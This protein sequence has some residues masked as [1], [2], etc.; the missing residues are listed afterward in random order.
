MTYLCLNHV[1][2]KTLQENTENS[3]T[4]QLYKRSTKKCSLI[5]FLNNAMC[6]SF[7][8]KG[9][10][11]CRLP[12]LQCI[13]FFLFRLWQLSG[14]CDIHDPPTYPNCTFFGPSRMYKNSWEYTPRQ[15]SVTYR[16]TGAT[17]AHSTSLP[18]APTCTI[19]P[20]FASASA[21]DCASH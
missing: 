13:Y 12:A 9:C 4:M 17:S 5:E 8:D 20:S 21:E 6:L 2:A 3:C 19:P 18:H 1:L 15:G 14:F 7:V 16:N 11:H 10:G